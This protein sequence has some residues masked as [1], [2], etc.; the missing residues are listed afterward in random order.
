MKYLTIPN[1]KVSSLNDPRHIF[2]QNEIF[3]PSEDKIKR[4]VKKHE[5]NRNSFLREGAFQG[6]VLF[7]I[8]N[9]HSFVLRRFLDR[10]LFLSM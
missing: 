4:L 6:N 10:K 7:A 8:R 5:P 2:C 3:K 1:I 9:W